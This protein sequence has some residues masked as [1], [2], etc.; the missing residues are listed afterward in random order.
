M[1][2]VGTYCNKQVGKEEQ[3]LHDLESIKKLFFGRLFV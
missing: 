3:L 1:S 2:F